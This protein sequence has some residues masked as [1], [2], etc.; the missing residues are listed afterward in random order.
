MFEADFKPGPAAVTFQ[1][2]QIGSLR[3]PEIAVLILLDGKDGIVETAGPDQGG[4]AVVDGELLGEAAVEEGDD[5]VVPVQEQASA[6]VS[7]VLVNDPSAFRV[8]AAQASADPQ[9]EISFLVEGRVAD[10]LSSVTECQCTERLVRSRIG[11]PAF[12]GGSPKTA[13]PVQERDGRRCACIEH[14]VGFMPVNGERLLVEKDGPGFS[15][16]GNLVRIDFLNPGNRVEDGLVQMVETAFPKPVEATF[17]SNPKSPVPVIAQGQDVVA[18]QGSLIPG[19]V[20]G[21]IGGT[22]EAVQS[23]GRPHPDMT[24]AVLG[25][26]GDF[27][28]GQGGGEYGCLR[29]Q[30]AG[31]AEHPR[32]EQQQ[33]IS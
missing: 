31:K 26:T 32:Q 1:L 15:G 28:I 18:V 27:R 13:I 22:V 9:P 3:Q 24:G 21:R 20:V 23:P 10:P 2:D 33:V 11:P 14:P 8:D 5:V 7:I 12:G 29:F 6:V 19:S 25:E 30:P 4:D 17:G 16:D